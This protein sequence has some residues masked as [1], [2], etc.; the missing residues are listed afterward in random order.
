MTVLITGANGEIGHGLIEALAQRPGVRVIGLDLNPMDESVRQLCAR[1]VAGDIN[2]TDLLE[3]LN[4][5]HDIETVFHLAAL[6]STRSERQPTLAHRVNVNGTLALLEAAMAQARSRGRPVKMIYPSSI[7]VYGLPDLPS[8]AQA[9]AVG[10]DEWTRPRTMY[11][12]NKLYCEA[13]GEYY[14]H[15]YRQLDADATPGLLDFRC[16]RFPGLI[17]AYTLPAG[18]TS[19]YG[20]EMLHAAAQ[21]KPYACFV[22]PDVRIPFMAMPDAVR[23]LLELADAPGAQLSRTSYNVGAFSPSAKEIEEQVRRFFPSAEV[24]YVPDTRRTAIVD[25]WP[26]S[27]DDSQARQDWGWQASLNFEQAFVDYLVPALKHRYDADAIR[28]IGVENASGT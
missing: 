24:D 3:R 13:L 26:E 21:G 4:A 7:A 27:V 1:T 28:S 8:K 2:D 25:S 23:A 16:V 22:R 6:L 18:G 9:G 20:A 11:G 19:D 15:H 14:A 10:E 5:E 17:S 12:V